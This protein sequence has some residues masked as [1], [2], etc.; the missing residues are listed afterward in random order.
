MECVGPLGI[1]GIESLSGI[2]QTQ[3]LQEEDDIPNLSQPHTIP[4][5]LVQ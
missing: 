5:P 2:R 4:F 1:G 3:M